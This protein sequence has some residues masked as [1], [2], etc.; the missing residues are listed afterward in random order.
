MNNYALRLSALNGHEKVVSFLLEKHAD[1]RVDDNFPLRQS[2]MNVNKAAKRLLVIVRSNDG[3]GDDLSIHKAAQNFRSYFQ[4]VRLLLKFYTAEAIHALVE[5][6]PELRQF[7]QIPT[8]NQDK[9]DDMSA[10]DLVQLA[11]YF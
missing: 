11:F 2:V 8:Y 10:A 6:F 7:C 5:N 9:F 1:A 4:V 3:D